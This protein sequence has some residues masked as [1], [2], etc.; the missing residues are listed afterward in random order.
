MKSWQYVDGWTGPSVILGNEFGV[1]Y[2]SEDG[3]NWSVGQSL[4]AAVYGMVKNTPIGYAITRPNQLY[5]SN[6]LENFVNNFSTPNEP[7]GIY[8]GN[9]VYVL[10][11][12]SSVVPRYY[13]TTDF[14]TYTPYTIPGLG[15]AP[16]G[17]YGVNFTGQYFLASE[18]SVGNVVARSVDGITWTDTAA[19]DPGQGPT[20]CLD[21]VN[22]NYY[23]TLLTNGRIYKS[24]DFITWSLKY[25]T[26]AILRIRG[27][28]YSQSRSE[29][30]ACGAGGFIARSVD[31]GENF[32]P[33]VSGTVQDLL[34]VQWVQAL[35]L[36][37]A[38]GANG[39]VITSPD[40]QTWTARGGFFNSAV[41]MM[42]R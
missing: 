17:V 33:Q 16:L 26:G 30:V 19:I 29:V 5:N 3:I 25:D 27:I 28:S 42:Q 32:I 6:N 21:Y 11:R 10:P 24:P 14:I 38:A 37:I 12:Y 40:A 36:W 1:I 23:A 35:G 39:T 31:N 20:I 34:N 18:D 41:R 13:Y 22:G 15:A 2:E 4:G 7:L 8:Y 9:G